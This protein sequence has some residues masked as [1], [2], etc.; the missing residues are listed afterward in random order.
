[1]TA[2]WLRPRIATVS[3]DTD[4]DTVDGTVV[5]VLRVRLAVTLPD[6]TD[7]DPD[8]LARTLAASVGA[9]VTCPE[10]G[11]LATDRQPHKLRCGRRADAGLALP[12][13]RSER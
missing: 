7:C 4:V 6:G 3:V 2:A 1:M 9:Q 8:E 11:R 5:R 13:D 10:C 12:A